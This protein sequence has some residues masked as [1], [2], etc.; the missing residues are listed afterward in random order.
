MGLEGRVS[1]IVGGCLCY[2]EV[3]QVEGETMP[4]TN[5]TREMWRRHQRSRQ[6]ASEKRRDAAEKTSAMA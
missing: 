1:A 6:R 5:E 3:R 2:T 4:D